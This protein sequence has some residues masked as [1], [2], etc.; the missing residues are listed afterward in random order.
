MKKPAETDDSGLEVQIAPRVWRVGDN[1]Y[2]MTLTTG[3]ATGDVNAWLLDGDAPVLFD[4]GTGSDASMAELRDGLAAAGRKIGDI[5]HL[6]LTHAHIDHCGAA[7]VIA[8]ESGC[9]V[10]VYESE[11]DRVRDFRAVSL[12]EIEK[13]LPAVETIGFSGPVGE[14]ALK[15]LDSLSATATSCPVAGPLP[16]SL[17]TSAGTVTWEHRPGHSRADV[18]FLVGDTGL[19][20]TGDHLLPHVAT[21]PSLDYK[22]GL[23]Y[24]RALGRYRESLM[25]STIFA[26]SVGCPG[27][28]PVFRDVGARA[29]SVMRTHEIRLERVRKIL[30]KTGQTTVFQVTCALFGRDYRWEMLMLANETAG[31][32]KYLAEQGACRIERNPGGPDRIVP[33]PAQA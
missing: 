21:S 18:V 19:V 26:G 3:Y 16:A 32:L 1:L 10:R 7:G 23:D 2:R 14:K 25:K 12:V 5:R 11:V 29:A 9:G 20:L 17:E 15:M 28:G 33:L 27:H 30:A 22:D 4:A 13:M 6:M 31:Y 24:H 8:A